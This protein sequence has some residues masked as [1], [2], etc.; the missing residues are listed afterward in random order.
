MNKLHW[1]IDEAIDSCQIKIGASI[2]TEEKAYKDFFEEVKE[3]I[4]KDE[5]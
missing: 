2:T 5:G 3:I 1:A 4:R